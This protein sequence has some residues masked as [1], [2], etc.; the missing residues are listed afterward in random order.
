PGFVA[1]R[2]VTCDGRLSRAG[3]QLRV[4]KW[5]CQEDR[6]R[7]CATEDYPTCLNLPSTKNPSVLLHRCEGGPSQLP[8]ALLSTAGR[9]RS[10]A[11]NQTLLPQRRCRRRYL[12]V[13]GEIWN[14]RLP[15]RRP[16][17]SPTRRQ[18]GEDFESPK[19]QMRFAR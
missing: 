15:A 9:Q 5:T 13:V 14:S 3:K 1:R 18:A 19:Q 12:Q 16:G 6:S 2:T 10:R 7:C 4:R 11:Q 8:R 17:K